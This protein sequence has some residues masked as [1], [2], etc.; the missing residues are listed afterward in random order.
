MSG[1]HDV[2]DLS[3]NSLNGVAGMVT[4][5]DHGSLARTVRQL[6]QLLFTWVSPELPW[7]VVAG[8]QEHGVEAER[9]PMDQA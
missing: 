7:R 8:F 2:W 6:P 4:L 9:I 1:L 3:R 5:T